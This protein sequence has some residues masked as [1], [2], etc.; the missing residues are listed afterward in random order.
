[1]FTVTVTAVD[2]DPVVANAIADVSANQDAADFVINLSNVFNDI[3]DANA[4]ITK[5]VQANDNSSL[6]TASIAGDVLT[7]D[8]QASQTGTA[9]ITVQATSNSKT[10]DDTFVV[11]VTPSNFPP[12]IT[13]G[14]GPLAVTM[15]ED[16]SP[17]V[18]VA[19]TLGAT[20][21]NTAAAGLTWS[22]SSAA[23]DGT[24]TVSGSAAAPTT[25]TYAPNADFYGSDSFVVQVTDG[26]LTD[27]ITV[28]VTVGE[29]SDAPVITQG[30]GPLTVSMSEDGNPTAWVAPELNA[31]DGDTA[32]ASLTWSVLSAATSGIA[33]VSGS[34]SSPPIF[35]YAPA[36]NFNGNDSFVVQVSDG[37]LTDTIT[38][39]VNVTT[40]ND[41]PVIT[42]GAGP[43]SVTMSE[44]GSPTAWSAP[45]LGATNV[46]TVDS[47]LVWSVSSAASNG[48]AT[49]SGTAAAPTTFTY[50]PN[51]DFSGND[52]FVVQVSD[53]VLTDTITVNVTVVAEYSTN[54]DISV[55][56]DLELHYRFDETDGSNVY[57]SSPKN[58][59]GTL[60]NIA[61]ADL[62]VSGQFGSGIRVPGGNS[63]ISLGVNEVPMGSNWTVS[64]WF[65]APLTDTGTLLQHTLVAATSNDRHVVFDAAGDRQLGVYNTLNGFTGSGFTANT[66]STGW[67]HLV[68]VGDVDN[69]KTVFYL[70]GNLVGESGL[71][72]MNNVGVIGNSEAGDERFADNLDDFRIYSRSLS[73]SEVST[74]YGNGNGDFVAFSPIITQGAGPLTKTGNEDTI[75]SWT[76]GELNATDADTVAGSLTW[77]VDTNATNGTVTVSGSGSSPS[78]FTYVPDGNFSGNDSFVVQVSDGALTDAITVTVTVTPVNDPPIITSGATTFTAAENNASSSFGFS[79]IDADANTTLIY[80]KSGADAGLFTLNVATGQLNFTS[81]PDYEIPADADANNTYD[82]TV[83]ATDTGGLYAEQSLS[84][85]VTDVL[86]I[87]TADVLSP[88]VW[89][90]VNATAQAAAEAARQQIMDN[91]A[92]YGLVS[93]AELNA[94]VNALILTRELQLDADRNATVNALILAREQQLEVE[95]NATLAANPGPR[96]L[97]YSGRITVDGEPFTGVGQF[98]YA[99]VNGDGSQTY[100]THDGAATDGEPASGLSI[101]VSQGVY[102]I[103]LGDSAITGMAPLAPEV[104]RGRSD[105]RLRIWFARSGGSYELLSPDQPVSDVPYAFPAP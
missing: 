77:S 12:V 25:F 85:T 45:T 93:L 76:A 80:S 92:V 20:D 79:V 15:S 70:D 31:T 53:G 44:D 42:Q 56:Q 105:V 59:Q 82:V 96:F 36:A 90:E 48:T 89:A 24:A 74:L 78:T 43:L 88:D 26:A 34:G 65:T 1:M 57:D 58:R 67:H 55:S 101:D 22:V 97:T 17:T 21:A 14:A 32:S 19:P 39:N 63:N 8:F 29:V 83:R 16:G 71:A 35:T 3:D 62:Q 72:A 81:P 99:F 47:T 18:W 2:D 6:V 102:S 60:I 27:T 7:L 40:V 66:L 46:D 87:T 86:E 5:A 51:A 4:S 28:N 49:V 13:Q 33:T 11:T 37:T 38:V 68:A 69:A 52:S 10:V 103:R 104:F 30:A 50:A 73:A 75:F 84:V 95:R 23:T 94:T 61:D 98:K 64:A 9:N 91:P 54:S 100:W 41:P